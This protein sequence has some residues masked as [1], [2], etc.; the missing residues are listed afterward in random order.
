MS[1][2]FSPAIF[3][4]KRKRQMYL[5]AL[6]LGLPAVLLAWQRYGD[7]NPFI[8]W[9]YPLLAGLLVFWI[10]LLL[11]RRIPIRWTEYFVQTTLSLFYLGKYV[12]L[13]NSPASAAI[14][15]EIHAVFWVMAILFI[16]GYI[17]ANQTVALLLALA[18]SIV[19]LGLAL[20]FLYPERYDL[21]VEVFRLQVRVAVIALLTFILAGIKDDLNKAERHATT[22]QL[23]ANTD[24]LTG[25]PNRRMLNALVEDWLKY[26]PLFCALLVDIDYFKEVNDAHGHDRGDAVLRSLAEMLKLQTREVDVVGRWGGEEFLLLLAVQSAEDG[27]EM[28]ERL[29]RN[30]ESLQPTGLPITISLGGTINRVSRDDLDALV[31]RADQALYQAKAAGR[32]CIRWQE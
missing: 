17:L 19:T 9:S 5:V 26:R 12:V 23:A 31:K 3:S 27:F 30:V 15:N 18:Y 1:V 7:E 4:E 32:N 11:I 6:L 29:R 22:L 8:G 21:F 20:W 16:L 2:P 14:Q 28:A 25:L 13:L 24:T 10:V